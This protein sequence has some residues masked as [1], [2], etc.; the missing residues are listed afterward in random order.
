MRAAADFQIL[1]DYGDCH[2][3]LPIE[4]GFWVCSGLLMTS[5]IA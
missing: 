3:N 4:S 5:R 2:N 1:H